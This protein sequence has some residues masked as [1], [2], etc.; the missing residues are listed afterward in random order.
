MPAATGRRSVPNPEVH[1]LVGDPVWPDE[2]TLEEALENPELVCSPCHR[3]RL[4][5]HVTGLHVEVDDECL[6]CR[7][8]M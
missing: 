3:A 5:D 4:A 1:V 8:E 2:I 6:A 7:E